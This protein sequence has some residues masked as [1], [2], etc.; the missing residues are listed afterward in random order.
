MSRLIIDTDPAQPLLAVGRE[1]LLTGFRALSVQAGDNVIVHSSLS[2]FGY[3]EGGAP[4]VLE[5]LLELLGPRG[6]LVMAYFFPLY[7]GVFDYTRPPAP[8]TG[9][10]PRQLRAQPGSVLSVHPSHPVVALG[11]AA[12]H[13]TEDHYRVSAVGRA[14]PIDRLAKLG[15]KVLLLGVQQ[16]ANTTLHTGEAYA[17]AGYWGQQRA[18]RPP[19][20]L[21]RLPAGQT[22]WVPLPETPGDSSGFTRSSRSWSN[23]A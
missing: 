17:G 14:S 13:L 18:D 12:A 7:E 2:S 19:G 8:Y 23:A 22:V 3:V 11:P 6:T 9:A 5:A 10:L 20:R 16:S 4:A 15:G 1:Q 21:M